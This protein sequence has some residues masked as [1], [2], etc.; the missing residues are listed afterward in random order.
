MTK[1]QINFRK[2]R[3][4]HLI[5][6][7]FFYCYNFFETVAELV[8]IACGLEDR[9]SGIRK[10]KNYL[11]DVKWHRRKIERAAVPYKSLYSY[12]SGRLSLGWVYNFCS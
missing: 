10:F 9:L 11:Q 5:M 7:L 4:K 8:K 3:H 12:C 6:V 2:N 1:E